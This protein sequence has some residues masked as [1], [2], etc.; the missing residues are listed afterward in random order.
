MGTTHEN[1]YSAT[2][3]S[4]LIVDGVK[5]R[6]AKTNEKFVT[7]SQPCELPPGTVAQIEITIDGD[8]SVDLVTLP[9]GIGPSSSTGAYQVA[10]PF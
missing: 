8:S 7:L 5:Y 3:E 4:Y 9:E 6:I 1:G 10:A 2:V